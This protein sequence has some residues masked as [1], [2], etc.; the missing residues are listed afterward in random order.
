MAVSTGSTE[1]WRL[2]FRSTVNGTMVSYTALPLS[3]DKTTVGKI[4]SKKFRTEE[5]LH[6]AQLEEAAN[7]LSSWNG[8]KCH[9]VPKEDQKL[10]KRHWGHCRIRFGSLGIR[11]FEA[12][13]CNPFTVYIQAPHLVL[14]PE[15]GSIAE[16][17]TVAGTEISEGAW[18]AYASPG[19]KNLLLNKTVKWKKWDHMRGGSIQGTSP[20]QRMVTFKDSKIQWITL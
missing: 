20:L 16:R 15:Y 17:E 11:L 7:P 5:S 18:I 10:I 19:K 4:T 14:D 2:S 3:K 8:S 9:S 1:H 12:L 13:I 6:N